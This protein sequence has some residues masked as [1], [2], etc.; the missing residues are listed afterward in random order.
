MQQHRIMAHPETAEAGEHFGLR[1]PRILLVEDYNPNI[2]MMTMFL[3]ILG[4]E[5]E[6][7]KSGFE[8]LDKFF[9]QP[10]DLVIMDLQ[11]P[12]IDGLEATRRMRL[13][14]KGQNLNPTPIIAA[15][16]RDSDED[17]MLCIKAGMNDC[18][19]KPFE[20]EKLEIELHRWLSPVSDRP[21]V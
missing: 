9:M 20:L 16:G 12:D 1:K 15:T 21:A 13:W 10:H 2:L 4:Y 8:A 3:E 7:A 14:E 11:L 18:F 5:C 6:V 19:S 17:K